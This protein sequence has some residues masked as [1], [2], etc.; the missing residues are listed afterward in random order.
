[1]RR[2][3]LAL[4]AALAAACG[5]AGSAQNAVA[6]SPSGTVTVFA[7]A[8][9]TNA[10][11]ALEPG[12]Q[13]R[14]PHVTL[15][16]DFAGSPTLVTQLSQGARADV[17]A[18]A[19]ATNM[20][21]AATDGVLQGGSTVFAH[22]LL[23]IAVAPGNPKH[24]TRLSDLGR[25][26]VTLVLAAPQVPAGKYAGQALARAGVAVHPKSLETDVESVLTKVALGEADAGIVYT[27]DVKAAAGRVTGI[28]IPAAQNVVAGYPVA[29][30]K[31]APNPAGARA[32]ITYL[33]SAA[34]QE[35]LLRY[36]FA[37]P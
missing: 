29:A 10:F 8:S 32:F 31:G 11:R 7:A 34:G 16:F 23:E 24:I 30:V 3:A 37:T 26:D 33:T 14:Y 18:T 5:T 12:F 28:A 19:D 27:T 35:V 17:L 9:L 25:A 36:G 15:S 22:N 20:A 13:A 4:V 21:N 6:G 1:M 2:A